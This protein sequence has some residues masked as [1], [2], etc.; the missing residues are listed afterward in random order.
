MT[1]WRIIVPMFA[2]YDG[3]AADPEHQR[4]A[5]TAHIRRICLPSRKAC[6][7]CHAGHVRGLG[8]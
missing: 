5:T 1:R 7:V 8:G 2:D 4:Q 6:S 3:R